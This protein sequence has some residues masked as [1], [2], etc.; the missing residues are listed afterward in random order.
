MAFPR[1]NPVEDRVDLTASVRSFQA[2]LA[3]MGEVK[4]MIQ[5]SIELL[6]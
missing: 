5:R 2:N 4:E 1:L 6:R 3:A